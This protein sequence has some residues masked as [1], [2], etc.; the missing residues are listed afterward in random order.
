M[1]NKRWIT[2]G[3]IL[4]GLL[5]Y[6][7]LTARSQE[8]SRSPEQRFDQLCAGCH[9]AGGTG[10]DR[11]PALL[12][13]RSLRTRS[14]AQ[15]EEVIRAG[16]SGG[17]PAFALPQGQLKDLAEW[18]RSLNMSAFETKPAGDVKSGEQMFFGTGQCATCHMVRGRGRANGPD[19]SDI[20]RKSTVRELELVLEN[21]TA[22]MGIH[23]TAACPNWAFCADETWGVVDVHLRDGKSI[24]GFARNETNRD[25]EVQDLNGRIHF[26]ASSDYDHIDREKA[27]YMPPFRGSAEERRDLL[28]YMSSLGGNVSGPLPTQEAPLPAEAIQ[29]AMHPAPGEWPNYD[30]APRGNRYSALDQINRRNVRLLKLDWVYALQSKGLETTPVVS[31]GVMYVTAPGQV[32]AIDARSGREIWCYQRSTDAAPGGRGNQAGG[33]G[34]PGGRGNQGAGNGAPGGF[35]Q[36]NRGTTVVG[37][38]VLFATSDAHLVCLNRL[39]GGVIWDVTMPETSGRYYATATPLVIGDLVVSGVGGGDGPLRGFLAAHKIT[40]GQLAWRFWTI[41]KPGEPGSETWVG[42]A[43][44]TG[45]GATWV[46][47]SYEAESDTLYWTVGNP[48]PATDGDERKGI[49][50]YTNCVIALEGKTGK[51]RWY[52]QFT[53]HDL[54]DWD[55]TEPLVMADAEYKGQIRK[56]LIQANRNGFFYVLD[57]SSGKLLFA[58]PFVDKLNWAGGI[59]EDGKPMLL[60]PNF[61]TKAGVKTCPAV[62]GATNWYSTSFSPESHLFYV[63]AVEDCSIYKQAG[64]GGYE[65]YRNP[66]DPGKRYLRAIDIETGRKVW[67]APQVGAQEANYTGV[68]STAGGIVFYGET[69]GSFAAAD[70]KTGKLLWNFTANESW[71]ASPMTYIAGGRQFVAIASG[72]NILSF[73]LPIRGQSE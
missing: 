18:L 47:G 1:G 22:Q 59:G 58:K 36:P 69:G 41:P 5:F 19:L 14:E 72:G 57:R 21:P 40:T 38:R 11:A 44:P 13:N 49:N 31:E 9:G 66:Q 12:N 24:R 61:P 53:P 56:L 67:E 32:C 29:A 4:T 63:M 33:N 26:L 51:L 16:T 43:L 39:T 17:M 8:S 10:G 34:A 42:D 71:K 15:I 25:I 28:A 30:G 68:L 48:F 7:A 45:G 64:R 37:D 35:R 60:P 46:T 20:G 27:S 23:T 62:R 50:L 52:F 3:A 73:A 6:A 65:G 54:H 70:S 2:G 55:A